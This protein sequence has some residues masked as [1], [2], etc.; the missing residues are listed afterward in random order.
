MEVKT[1][2]LF[3]VAY[4][5]NQ[6]IQPKRICIEDREKARKRK[7]VFFFTRTNQIL[8]QVQLFKLGKAQTNIVEFKKNFQYARDLMFDRL[9]NSSLYSEN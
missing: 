9:R 1:T 2:D 4:L 8:A 7:I 5:L 3:M 6:K